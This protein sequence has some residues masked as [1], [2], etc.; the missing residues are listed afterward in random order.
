MSFEDVHAVL[1]WI[2]KD[3]RQLADHRIDVYKPQPPDVIQASLS[4]WSTTRELLAF[5]TVCDGLSFGHFRVVSV[6]EVMAVADQGWLSV[7]GWGDGSV[8]C[9]VADGS[10]NHGSVWACM[11]DPN[12]KAL[13][14]PSFATWLAL[15]YAE[16]RDTGDIG[17]VAGKGVYGPLD[18]P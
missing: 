17:T 2:K 13:I 6:K 15:V 11:H 3:R 18:R 7:H 16:Y 14:A 5:Y 10:E 8:T 9:L 1:N 4:Q 12:R